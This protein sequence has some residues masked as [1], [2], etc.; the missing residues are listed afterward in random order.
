MFTHLEGRFPAPASPCAIGALRQNAAGVAAC[1]LLAVAAAL[2]Q[3]PGPAT[4][5]GAKPAGPT[6]VFTQ[7]PV[8]AAESLS[9]PSDAMLRAAWGDGARLVAWEPGGKPRVL[10]ASLDSACDPCVSFDARRILFAGKR[11]KADSWNIF[12]MDVEGSNLRQITTGLGDCRSPCYQSTL[13]TIISVEPW[14]QIAFVRTEAAAN[15]TDAQPATSLYSCKLDGSAVR[16]LTYNLS[17]TFD[18]GMM[19]DGRLV[20]SSWQRARLDGGPLGRID[21]FGV[22]TDGADYALFAD[23]AGMRVKQMACMAGPAAGLVTE[24]GPAG[25]SLVVFVETGAVP[26]DGAGTLGCVTWRRPLHSYRP[27]TRPEDGLYHS[28]SPLPDGAILVSRRPA[29]GGASHGIYRMHLAGGGIEPL[30]DDPHFHEIQAKVV[31]RRAMPDGRSSVVTE[32]DPHGKLYCL[33]VSVSDLP[34]KS[35][36]SQARTP[37]VRIL[38]GIPPQRGGS[39]GPLALRRIL[40]EVPLAADGSFH[41]ELPAN[42][43]VELQLLDPGGMAVRSCGWVWAKNHEARGCI[44]C[45][46]DGEQTPENVMADALR[47]PAVPLLLPEEERRSV[48]YVANV[49]PIVARR[50]AGCHGAGGAAPRL[51]AD[52]APE[53]YAALLAK[54]EGDPAAAGYRYVHPGRAR[55]SPLV[56]HLVGKNTSLPWDG[57]WGE[58]PVK[59]IPAGTSPP[60][61][62]EE[63]RTIVAW[64]DL[65]AA[66]SGPSGRTAAEPQP[67]RSG[68]TAP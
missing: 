62:D 36:P 32:E 6:I 27:L 48:D 40:G 65:G 37:V 56:W 33:G 58:R 20:L 63:V 26:W 60:L 13:Y 42:L 52:D 30:F 9:V 43:P 66:W 2:A 16:R 35:A 47:V 24:G 57:P 7:F 18:P 17:S 14:Q 41:L 25:E 45:H 8:A 31:C 59:A 11:T 4:T 49:A 5:S 38:E 44:G 21:L 19:P 34:A 46:E 12:E 22:N 68:E 23:P 54:E 39:S 1:W 64:I 53:A 67:A 55:T 50:C 29:D 28:P 51:D 3:E 15:E 61:E 10:T